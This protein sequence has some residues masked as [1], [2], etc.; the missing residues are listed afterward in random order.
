MDFIL[1]L[2][3]GSSSIKFAVF[4]SASAPNG[5]NLILKGHFAQEGA[6]IELTIKDANGGTLERQRKGSGNIAF[7]HDDAINSILAWLSA[8]RAEL[9]PTAVGHRVVH[10]GEKYSIPVVVTEKVLQDLEALVPLAPLHQPHNLKLI[11]LIR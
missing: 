10:G 11:H 8:H 7:D 9:I 5:L 3:A 6:N 1:V 2:N 4:N